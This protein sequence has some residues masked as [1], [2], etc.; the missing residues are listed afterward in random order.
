MKGAIGIV[1]VRGHLIKC[2]DHKREAI[3][4]FDLVTSTKCQFPKF[5]YRLK[6]NIDIDPEIARCERSFFFPNLF[7]DI[8]FNV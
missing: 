7:S 3:W 1:D 2:P 5:T 4:N 8:H 6:C